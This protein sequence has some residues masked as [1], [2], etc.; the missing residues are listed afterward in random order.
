MF[1]TIVSELSHVFI[2]NLLF[3]RH[4]FHSADEKKGNY[5]ILKVLTIILIKMGFVE[6]LVSLAHLVL[7]KGYSTLCI[8]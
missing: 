4:W 5:F 1:D 8:L 7:L 3:H 2:K 6:F